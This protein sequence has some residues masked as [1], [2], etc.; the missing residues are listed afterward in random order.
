MPS[1]EIQTRE[2]FSIG[3]ADSFASLVKQHQSMVFSIAY[4]ALRDRSV[5]EEVAQDVFLEL[6]RVL[7]VLDSPA[8]VVNW[9]RRATAHRAIDRQRRQ[10]SWLRLFLPSEK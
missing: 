1:V 3:D 6:H 5:A 8:H 10:R 9:L 2:L 4:S 7:P